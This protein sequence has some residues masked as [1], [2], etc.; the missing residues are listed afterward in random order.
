MSL[1][2]ITVTAAIMIESGKVFIA[3]RTADDRLAH[4]WE[5]PGGKLEL[6]ETPQQSLRREMNEEFGIEVAVGDFFGESTYA[7][8]HV[9]VRL[10]AYLVD[11]TDGELKPVDHQDCRWVTPNELAEYDFAPAD[12][13]FVEKLRSRG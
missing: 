11:W 1:D 3:Q 8:E 9:R 6:G 10:L 13:P 2:E 12:I 4:R 7:Y 5:F